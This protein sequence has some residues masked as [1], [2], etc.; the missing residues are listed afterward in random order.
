VD[1]PNFGD[2]PTGRAAHLDEFAAIEILRARFEAA[3]RIR[4]PDGALPPLG[5][6]WIGDDAAIVTT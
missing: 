2:P 5:D 6:T 1:T 3:A 4:Y